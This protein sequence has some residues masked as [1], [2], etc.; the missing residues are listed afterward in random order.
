MTT[1]AWR[2]AW[3]LLLVVT[4]IVAA[5]SA[6]TALVAFATWWVVDHSMT[7]MTPAVASERARIEHNRRELEKTREKLQRTRRREEG[8]DGAPLLERT[9]DDAGTKEFCQCEAPGTG[10]RCF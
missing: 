5:A 10:C 4:G 3:K 2:R 8:S 9:V 7:T 1:C 6:F